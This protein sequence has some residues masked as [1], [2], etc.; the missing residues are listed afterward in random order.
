VRFFALF[1]S[2]MTDQTNSIGDILKSAIARLQ[3][4]SGTPRSDAQAIIAHVI[5]KPREYVIAHTEAILDADQLHTF[6]KLLTLRTR[7]MPL[8][9]IIGRRAFF[10]RDFRINPHVLIPRPE[11][12]HV[13]EEALEWVR[14]QG[15]DVQ[16]VDVGTG[17][18]VIALTLAAKLPQSQIIA[19]DVSA[20]ALLVARENASG[21]DN[22][23]F[24]QGDL[25]APLHGP[26]DVICANLPYIATGEMN[27]LD[28]AKFEPHVALDGGGDGLVLI[29]KLL[30]QAPTR[31]ASHSLLLMEHGADQGP[32]VAELARRAFP[33]A[34]V[35]IVKDL[36]GLDRITWVEVN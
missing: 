10:D 25:L 7:G 20:A 16:L 9:Y 32:Q 19:T 33:H 18:G 35:Q 26:F 21:L 22:V 29:R 3:G 6:E 23:T 8:A 14:K 4:A 12:E 17:S 1:I 27:V 15:R 31:L 34:D 28:V 13:V 36:A 30:D 2:T 5:D 24:V 11:T